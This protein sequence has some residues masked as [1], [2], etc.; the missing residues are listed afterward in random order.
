MNNTAQTNTTI[1]TDL[2]TIKSLMQLED[3]I[4]S[5]F[6]IFDE[7]RR[8]LVD[9]DVRQK[10]DELL[11]V[12]IEQLAFH[13]VLMDRLTIASSNTK[14][15]CAEYHQSVINTMTACKMLIAFYEKE[16]K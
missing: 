15:A 8:Y 13:Q 16:Y 5:S 2:D 9:K 11:N 12:Q 3:L 6:A 4:D 14:A 1:I 10:L 7:Y